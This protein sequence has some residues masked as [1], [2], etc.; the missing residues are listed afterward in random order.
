MSEKESINEGVPSAEFYTTSTENNFEFKARTGEEATGTGLYDGSKGDGFQKETKN[1]TKMKDSE[2]KVYLEATNERMSDLL[3]DTRELEDSQRK[4]QV[5]VKQI[6][7]V[8][9]KN[10]EVADRLDDKMEAELVVESSKIK[11]LT[12]ELDSLGTDLNDKRTTTKNLFTPELGAEMQFVDS[13]EGQALL[14]KMTVG[15][16]KSNYL[17][18]KSDIDELLGNRGV[19]SVNPWQ[20]EEFRGVADKLNTKYGYENAHSESVDFK[21]GDREADKYKTKRTA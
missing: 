7:E 14:E 15:S 9:R 16:I 19:L 4:Q 12:T 8:D 3:K 17:K 20:E 11:E 5:L 2:L 6:E 10:K 18:I 21:E 1:L 13:E